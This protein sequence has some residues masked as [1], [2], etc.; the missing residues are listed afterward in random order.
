MKYLTVKNYN[1]IES[2]KNAV[3]NRVNKAQKRD[4]FNNYGTEHF[5][6]FDK[7]LVDEIKAKDGVQFSE[8]YKNSN[9][10]KNKSANVNIID[11]WSCE[12]YYD[13]RDGH[14]GITEGRHF[15]LISSVW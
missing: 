4:R 7:D 9:I 8:S 13:A 5:L 2:A 11:V 12:F 10:P 3:I 14:N 6:I 15:Y 1:E